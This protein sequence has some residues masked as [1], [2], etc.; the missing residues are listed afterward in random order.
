MLE[1]PRDAFLRHLSKERG[2]S[3]HT[4]S[5]YRRDLDGVIAW[6]RRNDRS[7][8]D[9]LGEA[10]L[11]CWLGEQHR[12]GM[13]PRSLQ[14]RLS[15]VRA[16]YRFLRREGLTDS[17]PARLLSA[18]KA[19]KPLPKTLDV[20][21]VGALLEVDTVDPLEIRD[22]AMLELFYSSGLRLAELVGANLE[23]LDLAAGEI[24]VVGKGSKARD[25]PVGNKARLAIERWLTIRSG[26]ADLS[27]R[28]L[29]LSQQ[30]GR[31]SAR[32]V[33]ARLQR[34]AVR[35]GVPSHLHPH[36][37]RHSFA[38]HLL[39]SS[40]DLRAVQELLGHANLSTTQVY[41]HL[42]FQHLAQV[43]DQAHPR[44]RKR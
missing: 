34:W 25:L 11:R 3:A 24:R 17:N 6:C 33:Q 29:F 28:A 1:Q 44:A 4:E 16:L 13:S 18:P 26:L 10:D 32:N 38:S 30:G 41:T 42:D 21:Q 40:G 39:E 8:W 19:D 20:D 7:A 15:A 12:K 5:A 31:I 22:L 36:K 14:R 23:D 37:L 9:E 27:Q 43:Y 35:N 2:L